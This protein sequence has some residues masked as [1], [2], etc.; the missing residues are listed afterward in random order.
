MGWRW[1]AV[2]ACVAISASA[3]A[4]VLCKTRSATVK[5]RD[6]CKRKET[7]IDPVALGLQGPKGDKGDMGDPGPQGQPGA[8]GPTGP[9]GPAGGGV[10]FTVPGTTTCPVGYAAIYTGALYVRQC[11]GGTASDGQLCWPSSPPVCASGG[12]P[13]PAG[14][15]V[16]CRG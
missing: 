11:I 4:A 7:Q 12:P 16:V 10:V 6:K 2:V 5:L 8:P 13:I 1:M 9:A 14:D 3:S 15:C